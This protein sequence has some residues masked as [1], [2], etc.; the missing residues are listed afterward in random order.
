MAQQA[1]WVDYIKEG[2]EQL[3]DRRGHL[4]DIYKAVESVREKDTGLS[5]D[6]KDTKWKGTIRN[7]IQTYSSDARQYNKYKNVHADLFY[8]LGLRS[9]FWGLRESQREN[10][11]TAEDELADDIRDIEQNAKLSS[12]EKD[13]LIKAR[14][15]QGKFRVDLEVRWKGRCAVTGCVQ[16]EVLRASHIKPWRQSDNGERLSHHNG[17]LLCANLDALFDKHLISFQDNGEM[18]VSYRVGSKARAVLGIPRKLRLPLL[19]E[20][21]CFLGF[22]RSAGRDERKLQG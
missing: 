9:G 22:H 20:E 19:P 7:T 4:R 15:G 11:A 2:F 14:R 17:I 10:A 1:M 8:S 16:S 6:W 18:I 5:D 3:P 12:T 21:K 13:A